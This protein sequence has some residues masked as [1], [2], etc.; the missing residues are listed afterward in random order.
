MI[1]TNDTLQEKTNISIARIREFEPPEGYWLAFSG[2]KDSEVVS[3]LAKKAGV[4]FSSHYNVTNI[5]PPELV[6]H[7]KR[8]HPDVVFHL[9]VLSMWRLIVKKRMPPTRAVRYC[10]E[11]L[12]EHGGEGRFIITGIRA[13]ESQARKNRQLVELCYTKSVKG[14]RIL[15]PII[16]WTTRDVWQ[17]I[18]GNN[19]PYCNLY[20]KGFKRI[21]CQLC[22][23]AGTKRQ[24]EGA[25]LYPWIKDRFVKSFDNCV[26]KRI[27]DGLPTEWKT[28]QEMYELIQSETFIFF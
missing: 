8:N 14:K 26:Q 17:Y 18:R 9:P 16:D 23:M 25:V 21:G 11:V 15:N 27:L 24:K 22:P 20:D 12:K 2:G 13:N 1:L 10:C 28:G 6:Y 3:D 19:L 4:K 5:D 7:I